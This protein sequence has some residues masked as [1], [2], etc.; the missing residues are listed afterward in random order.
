MSR[1][2]YLEVFRE[3]L[4]IRD[5]ESRLYMFV[6]VRAFINQDEY[7]SKQSI[8]LSLHESRRVFQKKKDFMFEFP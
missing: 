1:Y 6:S 7:S 5:N 2:G 8:R 4:G 3:P